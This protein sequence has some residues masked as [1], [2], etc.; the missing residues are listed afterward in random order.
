MLSRI[1]LA[2][3]AEVLL[4]PAAIHGVQF[5][6][7]NSLLKS[8]YRMRSGGCAFA[9]LSRAFRQTS[10][11]SHGVLILIR[12]LPE[13]SRH[14]VENATRMSRCA[15]LVMNSF[16]CGCTRTRLIAGLPHNS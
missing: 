5:G 8:T 6:M 4:V 7:Q 2:P 3:S 1:H 15:H 11:R 12:I 16:K 9:M 13:S 14:Q 10:A